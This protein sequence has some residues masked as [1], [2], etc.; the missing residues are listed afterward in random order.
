MS[1]SIER[2]TEL[3]AELHKQAAETNNIA[4]IQTVDDKLA[5][6]S[7][8]IKDAQAAL[9]AAKAD[10][11]DVAAATIAA[12]TAALAVSEAATAAATVASNAATVVA[13]AV[14]D[15]KEA[16]HEVVNQVKDEIIVQLK[17]ELKDSVADLRSAVEQI[18]NNK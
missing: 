7:A 9:N 11:V 17:Q 16:A 18:A 8:L 12:T 4:V 5:A 3:T 10:S 6:A 13:L 15:A 2:L 1:E 14:S